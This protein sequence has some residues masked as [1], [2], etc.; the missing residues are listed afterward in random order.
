MN[1]LEKIQ[2]DMK[3]EGTITPDEIE[4]QDGRPRMLAD[5]GIGMPDEDTVAILWLCEGGDIPIYFEEVAFL[6]Q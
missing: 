1:P 6:Y 3:I 2:H 5:P 4:M